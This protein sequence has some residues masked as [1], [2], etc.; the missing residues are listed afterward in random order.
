MYSFDNTD[1][2]QELKHL[3]SQPPENIRVRFHRLYHPPPGYEEKE[4]AGI[5]PAWPGTGTII[6][7]VCFPS[8][9][10]NNV[11]A[12]WKWPTMFL[13][14][15]IEPNPLNCTDIFKRVGAIFCDNCPSVSGNLGGCCHLGFMLLQLSAN[16]ALESTNRTVRLVN[17]KNP[18]FLHPN[19]VMSDIINHSGFSTYS[20]RHSQNKRTNSSLLCPEEVYEAD[21]VDNQEKNFITLNDYICMQ[22]GYIFCFCTFSQ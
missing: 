20:T 7:L 22:H 18:A 4:I 3:L 1:Q 11:R 5:L 13:L 10:S 9:R 15:S 2:I 16:W 19:E 8:N 17:M 14:D 6:Q 21:D 12:N